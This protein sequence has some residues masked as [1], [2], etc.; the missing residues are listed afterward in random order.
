MDADLMIVMMGVTMEVMVAI[1]EQMRPPFAERL[2]KESAI[3]LLRFEAKQTKKR[4]LDLPSQMETLLDPS[5]P[6]A[7]L[8]ALEW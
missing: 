7:L 2:I 5:Y 1:T 3:N 4:T 8:S 6:P